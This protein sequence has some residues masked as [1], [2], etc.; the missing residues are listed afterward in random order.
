MFQTGI[1]SVSHQGGPGKLPHLCTVFEAYD[2]VYHLW[3]RHSLFD[4]SRFSQIKGKKLISFVDPYR[5]PAYK[6]DPVSVAGQFSC[7]DFPDSTVCAKNCL[8]GFYGL[9]T[10]D[11]TNI[12]RKS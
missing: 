7:Q 6:P 5:I 8:H 12:E 4:G 11:K 2:K 3:A 1:N 9:A 10:D